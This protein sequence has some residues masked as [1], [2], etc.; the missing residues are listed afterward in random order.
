MSIFKEDEV[1]KLEKMGNE[2]AKEE[3]MSDWNERLYPL[4]DKKDLHKM[5][6]FLKMKYEEMRF[7]KKMESSDDD[8][9]DSEAEKKKKSKKKKEEKKKPKKH[10]AKKKKE[11][12]S[13]D[14]DSDS[15][16]E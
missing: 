4:P 11:S 13:S 9:S 3:L 15:E 7:A 16:E 14:D 5:K 8:S 2:K 10:V 6:E 1:I 12:S